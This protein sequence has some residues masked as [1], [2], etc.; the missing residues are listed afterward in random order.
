[1]TAYSDMNAIS[2][3]LI[4]FWAI[5]LILGFAFVVVFS[6]RQKRFIY[7]SA[8]TGMIFISYMIMQICRNISRS[9]MGGTLY[10][11]AESAERVPYLV[12]VI[13]MAVFTAVFLL[14]M[15]SITAYSQTHITPNAIKEAF[16]QNPVGVCY[17]GESGN[18]LI[19]NH[20]MNELAFAITGCGLLN[21]AELY[22]HVRNDHIVK[23]SDGKVIRFSHR[24]FTL[25]GNSCNELIADDIT[26]LY[27]KSEILRKD[28]ESLKL[29]NQRMKKYGETID[30]TVRRQEILHTKTK[31]H[32]EMN[33]L[34]ISTDNALI[35]GTDEEKQKILETW[36]KNILLLC[37]EA[38]SSA[39]NNVMSDLEEMSKLIG[40]K[41]NYDKQPETEDSESLQ[42][43]SI[44]VEEAMTNAAKHGGANNLFIHLSETD[45]MLSA[46]LSDDGTGLCGVFT[47]GGGL[48]TLRQRL[49][50]TKGKMWISTENKFVLTV[51]IRKGGDRS[52]V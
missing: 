14:N 43:F 1:M 40:I 2:R 34:L 33:R 28:N 15:R 35:S 6:A 24:L 50:Q 38:D 39:K 10:P 8:A 22:D 44:A 27:Q 5:L 25:N 52:A 26:E 36:Q 16:D 20:R 19:T 41:L 12:Y 11:L 4:C 7:S 49:E 29:R 48:S 42:L 3:N 32:A 37:I 17:Y 18:I 13:V 45:D 21:G 9:K 51:Q 30:E 31:I 23:L 47:E 46:E